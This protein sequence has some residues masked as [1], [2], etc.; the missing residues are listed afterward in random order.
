MK[1]YIS[2]YKSKTAKKRKLYFNSIL[3]TFSGGAMWCLFYIITY[4]YL[5]VIRKYV[6]AP[7]RVPRSY[8]LP[9]CA[10]ERSNASLSWPLYILFIWH[11]FI[12]MIYSSFVINTPKMNFL[13]MKNLP[14]YSL[15]VQFY[16]ISFKLS[17]LYN[18]LIW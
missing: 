5:I 9:S 6:W 10:A 8:M 12:L 2:S 15:Q 14:K 1:P 7:L 11:K 16:F 17:I 13:V 18:K 4:K 3:S